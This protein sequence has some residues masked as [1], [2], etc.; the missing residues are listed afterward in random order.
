MMEL[1]GRARGKCKRILNAAEHSEPAS[2]F[3]PEP[4]EPL[5]NEV[6]YLLSI[7]DFARI[8]PL[9]A[10]SLQRDRHTG[11]NGYLVRS[12]YFDS[13]WDED[14]FDVLDGLLSKQKVRLR[15]YP[16]DGRL[17]RLEYKCKTG[18]ESQK[19]SLSV[20]PAQARAL[21]GGDYGCLL[22]KGGGL[23]A[24]LYARMKMGCYRP[25]VVVDYRRRAYVMRPNDTR[26][27]FDFNIGASHA[28]ASLFDPCASFEPLMPPDVGVLEVKYT[29]FLY[30]SIK[31]ILTGVDALS[32]ANSKYAS[33]R[34]TI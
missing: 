17:F 4:A 12:L 7:A 23:A 34:L 6:K 19:R 18:R 24:E 15:C 2:G 9:L 25:R 22:Q 30:D 16:P 27:T 5:R 3:A 31:C 11:G 21:A 20:T 13:L 26:V 1:T 33:A 28:G 10:A 8:E 14:L 29:G 32:Q